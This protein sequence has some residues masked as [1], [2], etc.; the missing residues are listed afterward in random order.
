MVAGHQKHQQNEQHK[1]LSALGVP[2]AVG[3]EAPRDIGDAA[4]DGVAGRV[5]FHLAI[6]LDKVLAC[7]VRMSR[8][9]NQSERSTGNTSWRRGLC[10]HPCWQAC[11]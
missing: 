7:F 1:N 5:F 11:C 9:S 10:H 8:S 4:A 6:R 3:V 2:P